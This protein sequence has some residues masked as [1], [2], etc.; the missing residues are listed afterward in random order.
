M[1]AESIDISGLDVAQ[2][3]ALKERLW[4]SLAT[5]LN[6][7]GPPEWHDAELES[8]EKEW[9]ARE[10]VAEDWA[11]VREELRDDLP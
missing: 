8:R 2:R 3:I 6:R 9:H 11:R 7:T 4:D 10:E 1:K 5:D